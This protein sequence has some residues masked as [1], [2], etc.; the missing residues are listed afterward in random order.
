MV[1]PNKVYNS[2]P[3]PTG[4]HDGGGG[5]GDEVGGGVQVIPRQPHQHHRH[6]HRHSCHS[7][8]VVDPQVKPV[9]DDGSDRNQVLKL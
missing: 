6:H 4:D 9:E 7:R 8:Y 5:A 3:A 2:L 1:Y